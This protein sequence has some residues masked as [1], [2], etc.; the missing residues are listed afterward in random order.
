MLTSMEGDRDLSEDYNLLAPWVLTHGEAEDCDC[1]PVSSLGWVFMMSKVHEK[2]PERYICVWL[3]L[4]RTYAVW[5]AS[6]E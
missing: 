2:Y 4:G 3:Q 6:Y 1:L 5:D